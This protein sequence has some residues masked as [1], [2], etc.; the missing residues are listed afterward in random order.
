M[1]VHTSEGPAGRARVAAALAVA[2]VLWGSAFAVI[3]SAGTAY[4]AGELALLRFTTA[5]VVLGACAAAARVP[6]P[7]GRAVGWFVVSGL[8]G[9]ALYHP[10]LNKGEQV[11]AAGPAALLINS[12]PVWTALFAAAL[13]REKIGPRKILGIAVSFAGVAVLTVGQPGKIDVQP[14]ALLIVGAAICAALYVIVQKRFLAGFGALAF[15][16]WTVW[17]GVLL[18]APAF[19]VSTV[20]T[21]LAAPAR[22][23]AEVV[24]LG[25]F[26]GAIAYMTFAYAT[27][28]LP[29]ARVMSFMYFVPALSMLMAWP[30]LG[31]V[32]TAVS[33]AGGVLAIGGVAIVNAA[34]KAAGMPRPTVDRAEKVA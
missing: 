19:G 6:A 31:E 28:R 4:G 10:L 33:L 7:R 34:P 29:A 22:A 21:L 8:L 18:L 17:A 23:T 12:A 27:V 16:L 25:V 24:Y 11:V 2:M 5:G 3:K 13:L 30:Y 20:R 15:T 1:D 14:A 32:P 26:P 9:V